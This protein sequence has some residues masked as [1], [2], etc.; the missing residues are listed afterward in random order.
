MFSKTW[1]KFESEQTCY[2]IDDKEKTWE[3]ANESCHAIPTKSM[4]LQSIQDLREYSL[5]KFFLR[6]MTPILEGFSWWMSLF[7]EEDTLKWSSSPEEQITFV[8]W[9][10]HTNFHMRRSGGILTRTESNILWSL[11]ETSSK[12]S[13]ICEMQNCSETR[14]VY[15]YI[16]DKT[17]LPAEEDSDDIHHANLKCIPFGW[18]VSD[19]VTWFKDGVALS[20]GSLEHFLNVTM[21]VPF[22]PNDILQFQG[23]YWCSVDIKIPYQQIY[24]PKILIRSP[25]LHTFV[26]YMKS[27]VE[28]ITNCSHSLS[29]KLPYIDKLNEH[30]KEVFPEESWYALKDVRCTTSKMHIYEHVHISEKSGGE[31]KLRRFFEEWIEDNDKIAGILNKLLT[32]KENTIFRSTVVC[33]RENTNYNGHILTWPETP[34]GES[35]LPEQLCLTEEGDA[36]ERQCLGDFNTGAYWSPVEKGCV[37]VQSEVTVTLYK[38]SK[39]DISEENILSSTQTMERLTV[40]SEG[41]NSADVKFIS[42]ILE[43]VADVPAI[44]SEVLEPVVNTVDTVISTISTSGK[45]YSL[46]RD[47]SRVFCSMESI[48]SNAETSGQVIK[49]ARNNIAATALPLNSTSVSAPVGGLLENWGSNITTIVNNSS[50]SSDAWFEQ[51]GT[52]EAA[53]LVPGNLLSQNLSDSATNIAMAI[54]KNIYFIKNAKVISPV[55]DVAIGKERICNLDPPV[56]MVFRVH[57]NSFKRKRSWGCVFWDE[58]LNYPTGGWSYQ[59]CNSILLN[60]THVRC[61]C[62]HLTS[63]AVVMVS[64]NLL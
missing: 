60:G 32:S 17:E 58:R 39:K 20:S 24:S 40:N 11:K 25:R 10:R 15:V 45:R 28:E 44:E 46:T 30:L 64:L 33:S 2:Y 29:Y 36:L 52:F 56:Q 22:E 49:V 55:I 9:E 37:S 43:N 61:F 1:N 35:T 18:F 47:S 63:F 13:F 38:L 48:L 6:K 26:L 50:Q 27:E 8:D 4:L 53:V 7:Q 23:Y 34:I 21:K 57:K 51:H 14:T 31:E 19:S 41:I 12:E 59:G 16:E 62:N 3:E 5:F 42:Q 54:R